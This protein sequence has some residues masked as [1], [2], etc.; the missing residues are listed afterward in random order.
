MWLGLVFLFVIVL[1]LLGG[2][3]VG[4]IY[5]LILLPI[6]AIILVGALG[7]TIWR[8]ANDPERRAGPAGRAGQPPSVGPA[9]GGGAGGGAAGG[10]GGGAAGGTSNSPSSPTTP[11]E[12]L[13]ER[14]S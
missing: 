2:V 12:L 4:G 7:L 1:A 9:G 13:D 3:V 8:R 5:A 10:P 6:A 11:D 14:R